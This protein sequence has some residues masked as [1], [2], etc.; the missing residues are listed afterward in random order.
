MI[1]A[2]TKFEVATSN[3]LGGDT[4]TRNVTDGWTDRRRDGR[5]ED[6]LWYEINIPYFSNE[7]AGIKIEHLLQKSNCS[8]FHNIFQIHVHVHDISKA[9]LW[10]KGLTKGL[11]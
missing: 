10:S 4:I 3:G 2:S 5:T 8:I 7:K 9:F 11:A 1:Y 6:R